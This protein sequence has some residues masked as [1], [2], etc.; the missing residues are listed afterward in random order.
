MRIISFPHSFLWHTHTQK[1]VSLIDT[2]Q[3]SWSSL[4]FYG[5]QKQGPVLHGGWISSGWRGYGGPCCPNIFQSDET[6]LFVKDLQGWRF[7]AAQWSGALFSLWPLSDMAVHCGQNSL[8]IP[9][10]WKIAGGQPQCDHLT[11]RWEDGQKSSMDV[12]ESWENQPS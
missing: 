10:R 11:S 6:V 1:S 4:G 2:A 3:G 7:T 5:A 8:L 12:T 9:R